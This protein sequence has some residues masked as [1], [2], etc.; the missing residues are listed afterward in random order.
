VRKALSIIA[1]AAAAGLSAP[2]L[3]SDVLWLDSQHTPFYSGD[4]PTGS[5]LLFS[6]AGVNVRASA[7]SIGNDGNIYQAQLGVWSEGLGVKNGAGDN[8]HT[9]DNSGYKDFLLFQFD[10]VVELDWARFNTGWHG[11]NDT[12]A[13]IGYDLSGLPFG[14]LPGWNGGSQSQLSV[15]DFYSSNASSGD[16]YR[17]INP[18][19]HTGNL[20]IIGASFNNPDGS[21]KLD[22]F[23]LEKLTFKQTGGVPEPSTWAM[24][25]VGF[26]GIGGTLRASRRRQLGHSALS[27]A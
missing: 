13:T 21:Y 25:L 22:G 18:S 4:Q 14:T 11:M 19:N 20:W 6:S 26:F 27:A 15:F 8:S 5:S 9:V 1:A 23:K 3:A 16:S 2:A 17:D 12:D 10:Q 7:W 24:L